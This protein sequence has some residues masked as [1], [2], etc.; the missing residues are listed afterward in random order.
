MKDEALALRDELH[1]LPGLRLLRLRLRRIL[2]RRA[3]SLGCLL[4]R[5]NCPISIH[6]LGFRRLVFLHGVL[7]RLGLKDFWKESS[8]LRR[9]LARCATWASRL[10]SRL[11][12]RRAMLERLLRL[13]VRHRLLMRRRGLR[14]SPPEHCVMRGLRGLLERHRAG[15]LLPEL[16]HAMLRERRGL[17]L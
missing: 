12:E 6:R 14:D 13:W 2:E 7:L 10:S 8:L 3:V 1:R 11:R 5:E 9:L 15:L 4:W 16:G 17:H